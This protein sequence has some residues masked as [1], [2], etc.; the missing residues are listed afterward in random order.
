MLNCLPSVQSLWV[1]PHIWVVDIELCV[2]HLHDVFGNAVGLQE[3]IGVETPARP[4]IQGQA[5]VKPDEAHQIELAQYGSALHVSGRCHEDDHE[6]SNPVL[7]SIDCKRSCLV[8]RVAH[9]STESSRYQTLF[10]F[11]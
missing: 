2:Q 7:L 3:F 6:L 4:M 11:I 9:Y 8:K 1:E 5:V 10:A